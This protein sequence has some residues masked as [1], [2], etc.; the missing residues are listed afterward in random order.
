MM[1]D[2]W[3]R[4]PLVWAL[5]GMG[6]LLLALLGW[7]WVQFEA[8]VWQADVG[9]VPI[10]ER[11][12]LDPVGNTLAIVALVSMVCVVLLTV[13]RLNKEVTIPVS[14]WWMIPLLALLGLVI[15]LYL[16]SIP[17]TT[18]CYPSG[19]CQVIQQ[20]EY[21]E[22]L[23]VPVGIWGALGYF[24]I[25]V[26]WSASLI[27]SSRLLQIVPWAL[28]A[29]TLLGV[30][31]SLYFTFLEPFVIGA[32]CPWCLTSAILMTILFWLSAETVQSLRLENA[33]YG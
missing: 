12:T 33:I 27:G 4:K 6:L 23:N 19:A 16:S 15:M 1:I 18:I 7:E 11:L 14:G 9:G 13:Y 2:F 30:L 32:T 21:G 25:L 20:S 10:V 3:K 8:A 26:T 28:L 17:E 22:I 29:L 5:G 31:F 24:A